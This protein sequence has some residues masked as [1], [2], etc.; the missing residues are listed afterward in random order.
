MNDD[1][2]YPPPL[3]QP[4]LRHLRSSPHS[5]PGGVEERVVQQL[6]K[7]G[8]LDPEP[9]KPA[10]RWLPRAAAAV[11]L[12]GLGAAVGTAVTGMVGS[13]DSDTLVAV[14]GEPHSQEML[15]SAFYTTAS[16]LLSTETRSD[17]LMG[18]RCVLRAAVEPVRTEEE[19]LVVWF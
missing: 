1:R 8:R 14:A 17:L 18:A 11:L 4:D 13:N 10:A 9:R 3:D 16:R 7:R 2:E 19:V 5:Y 12:F 15:R 6:R